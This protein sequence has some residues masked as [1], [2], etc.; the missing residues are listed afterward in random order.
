MALL[1]STHSCGFCSSFQYSEDF[2]PDRRI[3]AYGYEV[4][5]NHTPCELFTRFIKI[6]CPKKNVYVGAIECEYQIR[7][8][9]TEC[10]ECVNFENKPEPFERIE[11]FRCYAKPYRNTTGATCRMNRESKNSDCLRC[12][13]FDRGE[14]L[15]PMI[16]RKNL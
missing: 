16:R 12:S 6:L 10:R 7:L 13:V 1:N 5:A 8:L 11:F 2:Y 15:G 3:C 9:Y 4:D 14:R